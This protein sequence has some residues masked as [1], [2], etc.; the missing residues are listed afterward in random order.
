MVKSELCPKTLIFF[1]KVKLRKNNMSKSVCLIVLK[2]RNTTCL[3]I[4]MYFI[5]LKYWLQERSE[6]RDVTKGFIIT[7]FQ[8]QAMGNGLKYM[9]SEVNFVNKVFLSC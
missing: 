7:E 5:G 8:Y 3:K 4:F 6:R 9:G 2:R 1:I